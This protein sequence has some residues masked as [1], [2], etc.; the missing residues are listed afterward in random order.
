MVGKGDVADPARTADSF[1]EYRIGSL[2]RKTRLSGV[3]YRL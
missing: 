3:P 2:Q 1:Y